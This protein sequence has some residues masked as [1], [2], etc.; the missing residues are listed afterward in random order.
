[1]SN[2]FD[3][4]T[5]G[6]EGALLLDDCLGKLSRVPFPV[7]AAR[8]DTVMHYEEDSMPFT[9]L[10]FSCNA[11]IHAARVNP[12]KKLR[13]FG[14]PTKMYAAVTVKEE[15]QSSAEVV[16]EAYESVGYKCSYDAEKGKLFICWESKEASDSGAE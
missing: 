15:E 10:V 9:T 11:A 4:A 13:L 16:L 12:P 7:E 2:R 3:E 8:A 5:Y 14:V 1:M 6:K